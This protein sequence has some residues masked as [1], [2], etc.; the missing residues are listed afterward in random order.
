MRSYTKLK[1]DEYIKRHKLRKSR[2][3]A[4]SKEYKLKC[5][6]N[7][8]KLMKLYDG[9]YSYVQNE[10]EVFALRYENTVNSV[11][12]RVRAKIKM[13]LTNEHQVDKKH[14][15]REDV[16]KQVDAYRQEIL[17]VYGTT[18]LKPEQKEK[19]INV[20]IQAELKRM[21]YKMALQLSSDYLAGMSDRTFIDLAIKT[22]H[23][24]QESVKKAKKGSTPSGSVQ[25]LIKNIQEENKDNGEER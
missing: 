15:Y 7:E 10:N 8:K 21:E 18:D 25:K 2:S 24:K 4:K 9:L 12:T 14:L 1:F 19:F 13:A 22:G 5:N 6:K 11:K 16:Q 17:D 20:K 23:L 3:H